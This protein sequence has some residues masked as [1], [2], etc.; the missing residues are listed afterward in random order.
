MSYEK[1]ASRLLS[2]WKDQIG[3]LSRS[4]LCRRQ[5]KEKKK[6]NRNCA[7]KVKR[8]REEYGEEWMKKVLERI[9]THGRI[10]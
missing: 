9:Q 2:A 1:L 6:I 7:I 3:F 5:K 8:G 10:Y 4:H